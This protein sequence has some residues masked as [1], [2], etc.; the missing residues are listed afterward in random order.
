MQ[1][2]HEYDPTDDV[3]SVKTDAINLYDQTTL[4]DAQASKTFNN[5]LMY[6][7]MDVGIGA[8]SN[9]LWLF[10]GTGDYMNLNDIM[11]NSSSVKNIMYGTKDVHFPYFG[12]VN[13]PLQADKLTKCKNTT[14][15]ST[16]CLLYTS[17]S[18][19]DMRRSRMP[20]SA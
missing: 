18:P 7:P 10:G 17:P 8:R 9:K 19:R 12:H 5:R 1:Y 14:T 3:L 4:F 13:D 20:S 2:E 6:H 11:I 16:G 15:D